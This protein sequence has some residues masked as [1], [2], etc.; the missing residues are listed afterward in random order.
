MSLGNDTDSVSSNGDHQDD[1]DDQ[2]DLDHGSEDISSCGSC[3]L[4]QAPEDDRLRSAGANRGEWDGLGHDPEDIN[5]SAPSSTCGCDDR[6]LDL[7]KPDNAPPPSPTS[8]KWDDLEHDTEVLDVLIIG[9][10]PSGLAAAA[11]I[12]EQAPAAMF[13]DEEHRRYTWLSKHGKKLAIKK[14][15]S[16][17]VSPARRE[18]EPEYT[19]KVLDATQDD[20]LGSW[21]DRFAT[22]DI[23]HLRS[24]MIWHVDPQDRDSLL[25]HVERNGTPEDMI[26]IKHCVGKEMSKHRHK[27]RYTGSR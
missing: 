17:T 12:R 22:F 6:D 27:T 24:P 23:R 1:Q 5:D 9:G 2:E 25:R 16:G 10:G 8:S 7:A 14:T 21:K 18:T 15:R 3:D 11:R 20:W 19:M 13:T 26:E 4:N